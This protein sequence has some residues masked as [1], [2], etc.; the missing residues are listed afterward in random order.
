[1]SI[2]SFFIGFWIGG[3]FGIFIMCLFQMSGKSATQEKFE[4]SM[5][6]SVKGDP[7]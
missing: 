7:E 3:I 5:K 1:M 2:L 6:N 4:Q